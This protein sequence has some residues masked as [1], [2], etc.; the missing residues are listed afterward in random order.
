MSP[1]SPLFCF[2]KLALCISL[3]ESGRQPAEVQHLS[4]C[5]YLLRQEQQLKMQSAAPFDTSISC[6]LSACVDITGLAKRA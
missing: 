5:L 2:F 3:R 1:T 6:Q 4:V